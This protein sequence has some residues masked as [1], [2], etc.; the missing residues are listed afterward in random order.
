MFILIY[1]KIFFNFMI[2]F[3]NLIVPIP[4]FEKLIIEI[5]LSYLLFVV[6]PIIAKILIIM[7]QCK[8]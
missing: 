4:I 7:F 1:L 3:A 2:I 8:N 6:Y 5:R